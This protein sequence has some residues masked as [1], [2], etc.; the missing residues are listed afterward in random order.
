[1]VIELLLNHVVTGNYCLHLERLCLKMR[2]VVFQPWTLHLNYS[3]DCLCFSADTLW[4][5]SQTATVLG[6]LIFL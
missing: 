6:L 1:M 3:L 5:L 2:G 4:G